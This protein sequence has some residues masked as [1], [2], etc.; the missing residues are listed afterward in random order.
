MLSNSK[1][2][3]LKA[4]ESKY[5][6]G[7]FNIYNLEGL[8][9]VIN[10]AE[11]LKS[12]V[13]VQLHPISMEWNSN[14]I[15][16][17]CLA[18][19]K[20]SSVPVAIHLD[21]SQDKS[22]IEIALKHGIKTVMAD[23]SDLSFEQNLAFTKS[24]VEMANQY[25]ASVEGEYGK[26]AGEEDGLSVQEY[27]AKMTAPELADEYV[28]KTGVSS[29]AV[30]IGNVHGKY[31]NEPNLDFDRLAAIRRNV[32]VPLV[33]HGAS[34]IPEAMVKKSISLGICKFNV[35]TEVRGAYLRSIR[36]IMDNA[37]KPEI[38]PIIQ[39]AVANMTEVIKRKIILFGSD[40]K[41]VA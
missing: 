30:C 36:D 26:L 13:I 25:D 5:A 14:R 1:E 35:N 19:A 21:H 15:I 31:A 3:L 10:A 28:T 39:L 18:A 16:S 17:A 23:G 38:M 6:V 12:P 29:L 24:V 27:E 40:G 7:A 2:L 9:A 37:K 33:L 34:G 8:S 32:N 41:H 4:Q 22:A 11:D 20:E